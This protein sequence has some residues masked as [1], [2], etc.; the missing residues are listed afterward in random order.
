MIAAD[1]AALGILVNPHGPVEQRIPCPRCDHGPTDDALGVNLETGA[2]HCFRCGWKG[3]AG[4]TSSISRP[5]VRIDDPE[6]IERKK[7]RL[8]E[9]WRETVPLTDPK[10][11]AVR[12][13]LASRALG[14]ILLRPALALRAHPGLKYYEHGDIAIY[15]AMVALFTGASGDAVTI[16]AT[17]LRH[18]GGAKAPVST[19]KK[20]LQVPVRGATRGGAIRLYRPDDA[21]LGVA[22][23]IETAL[24]LSI[25]ENIPVWAASS[26]DAL[27]RIQLPRGLRQLVIG[28]DLDEN[29]KGQAAAKALA[30]RVARRCKVI[31]VKPALDAPSDLNDELRRRKF[32]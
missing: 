14:E 12:S 24:S 4:A 8:R 22:E 29:G 1:F 32:K 27:E 31:Y 5:V 28:V 15:P 6:L 10:A 19:P 9:I 17:Y 23:G 7:A 18:D 21:A 13:Y 16:H 30:E 26:A 3:R 11:Y 20:L 25:L 2:Y